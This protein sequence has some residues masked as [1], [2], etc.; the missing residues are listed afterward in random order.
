MCTESSRNPGIFRVDSRGYNSI[1]RAHWNGSEVR[2]GGLY[3]G[4]SISYEICASPGPNQAG[5]MMVGSFKRS[6][7]GGI[8]DTWIM[9]QSDAE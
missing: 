4:R 9:W 6:V 3:R 2:S 5:V 1:G 7:F 8:E